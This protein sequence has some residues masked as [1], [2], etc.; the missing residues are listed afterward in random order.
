MYLPSVRPPVCPLRDL[1]KPLLQQAVEDLG[2]G[3]SKPYILKIFDAKVQAR[4]IHGDYPGIV[5]LYM[6]SGP[7]AQALLKLITWEEAKSFAKARGESLVAQL[8]QGHLKRSKKSTNLE[9]LVENLSA[10]ENASKLDGCLLTDMSHAMRVTLAVVNYSATPVGDLDAAVAVLDHVL[11]DDRTV[12]RNSVF[13]FLVGSGKKYYDQAAASLADRRVEIETQ[14]ELVEIQK[15][16]EAIFSKDRMLDVEVLDKFA[17]FSTTVENVRKRKK[18]HQKQFTSHQLDALMACEVKLKEQIGHHAMCAVVSFA[19]RAMKALA[20]ALDRDG[21]VLADGI[22]SALTS[23]QLRELLLPEELATHMV[24]ASVCALDPALA[25]TKSHCDTINEVGAAVLSNTKAWT[26]MDKVNANDINLKSVAAVKPWLVSIKLAD[27]V[28]ADCWMR[29]WSKCSNLQQ[30]RC[31]EAVRLL[32]HVVAELQE[33]KAVMSNLNK[34]LEPLASD[35]AAKSTLLSFFEVSTCYTKLLAAGAKGDPCKVSEMLPELKQ[36]IQASGNEPLPDGFDFQLAS[37]L[38]FVETMENK[39]LALAAD[40]D[41]AN[42]KQI[43]VA[44]QAASALADQV[45]V[46]AD[47][48]EEDVKAFRVKMKQLGSKIAAKQ[49]ALDA[50]LRT[51]AKGD[52]EKKYEE[53]PAVASAMA[54][55]N[56]CLEYTCVYVALALWSNRQ[57]KHQSA[58][59]KALQGK[60]KGALDSAQQNTIFMK[61]REEMEKFLKENYETPEQT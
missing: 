20:Q 32:K 43:T 27:C 23:N 16:S 54:T 26:A 36:K 55:N 46:G 33:G 7:A 40:H 51:I 42:L 44:A 6:K 8:L 12:A 14:K 50:S 53:N 13:E 2:Y 28:I 59:G 37:L 58:I 48:T 31:S 34:I 17:V 41:A 15:E 1:W 61:Q 29:V 49:V 3:L 24:W 21:Y 5:K 30:N 38:P 18:G 35:S 10:L 56:K 19:E 47:G 4:L 45:P 39:S 52:S 57:L 25:S 60:L 22:E 11:D 9:E